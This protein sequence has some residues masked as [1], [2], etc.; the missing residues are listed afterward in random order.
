MSKIHIVIARI[1]LG[2]ELHKLGKIAPV[3]DFPM[4]RIVEAFEV[5]APGN[6][7]VAFSGGFL[8]DSANNSPFFLGQIPEAL[9]VNHI[10]RQP[11]VMGG[12]PW[13]GPGIAH[14]KEALLPGVITQEFEGI[15]RVSPQP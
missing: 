11:E 8:A 4:C 7:D 1:V 5:A 2:M 3:G 10:N 12:L 6:L 13:S 15:E 14:V 9:S